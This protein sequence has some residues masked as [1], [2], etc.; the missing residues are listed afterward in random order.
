MNTVTMFVL[1]G[2][3]SE[4]VMYVNSAKLEILELDGIWAL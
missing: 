1:G 3:E 4:A 2:Y